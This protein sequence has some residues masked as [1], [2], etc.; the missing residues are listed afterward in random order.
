MRTG[1]RSPVRARGGGRRLEERS[2]T[3]AEIERMLFWAARERRA[4]RALAW[5]RS[6]RP[7][8]FIL[9]GPPHRN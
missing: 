7:R 8:A 6:R 3:T 9:A 4:E 5:Y 1:Q 2:L